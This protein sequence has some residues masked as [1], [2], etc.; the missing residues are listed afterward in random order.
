VVPATQL[1]PSLH[2]QRTASPKTNRIFPVPRL[3]LGFRRCSTDYGACRETGIPL[4]TR[5]GHIGTLMPSEPGCLIYPDQDALDFADLT[6][7]AGFIGYP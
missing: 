7:V 4:C 5:I 1:A 6:I 3:K 2:N